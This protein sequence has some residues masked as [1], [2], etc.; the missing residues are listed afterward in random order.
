MQ[1]ESLTSPLSFA[2]WQDNVK[3]II[4]EIRW[5]GE[6]IQSKKYYSLYF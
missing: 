4:S 3:L 2:F 5:I 6:E 1:S